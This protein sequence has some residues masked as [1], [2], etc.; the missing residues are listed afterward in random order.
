MQSRSNWSR[1]IISTLIILAFAGGIAI[2]STGQRQG[3]HDEVRQQVWV[4][5][6][7][8]IDGGTPPPTGDFV[9]RSA[10]QRLH[11]VLDGVAADQVRIDTT[12]GKPPA[13]HDAVISVGDTP[14]LGLRVALD[15]DGGG[16]VIIG[17]WTP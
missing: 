3:A 5:C 8:A 17:H 1:R 4:M 11:E 12:D 13:T 9:A 16:L 7:R 15:G 6:R 2:W 14:V 10:L